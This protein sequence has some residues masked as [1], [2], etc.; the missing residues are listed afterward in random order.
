MSS[1]SPE[2]NFISV[3]PSRYHSTALTKGGPGKS[4]YFMSYMLYNYAFKQRGKIGLACAIAFV[5]FL[6]IGAF[7]LL[8][9]ATSKSWIFY[10]GGDDK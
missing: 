10:E 9:F 4:S 5:L 6:L 8:L 2:L 3:S 1:G 7:T